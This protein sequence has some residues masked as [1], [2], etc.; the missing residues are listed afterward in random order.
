[1]IFFE[2]ASRTFKDFDKI[3]LLGNSICAGQE[4]KRGTTDGFNAF[5]ALTVIVCACMCVSDCVCDCEC[6]CVCLFVHLNSYVLK[7][8][9]FWSLTCFFCFHYSERKNLF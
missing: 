5:S 1:M 6:V 4:S 3:A 8:I 7:I 2:L 9:S